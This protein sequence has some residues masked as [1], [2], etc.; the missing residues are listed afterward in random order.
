M[1]TVIHTDVHLRR[2]THRH[3]DT[4]HIDRQRETHRTTQ[5]H[6]YMQTHTYTQKNPET[7]GHT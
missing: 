5:A 7:H 2:Y 1:G 6:S 3:I 4:H